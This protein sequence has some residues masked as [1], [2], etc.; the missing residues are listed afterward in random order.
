MRRSRRPSPCPSRPHAQALRE[1]VPDPGREPAAA[2]A[3]Q[4]GGVPG[5]RGG[6]GRGGEGRPGLIPAQPR[7]RPRRLPQRGVGQDRAG[8]SRRAAR[9]SPLLFGPFEDELGG[10]DAGIL[11]HVGIL[12]A[13]GPSSAPG[14]AEGSPEAAAFPPPGCGRPAAA[15]WCSRRTWR[16]RDLSGKI[17]REESKITFKLYVPRH[18]SLLCLVWL[19][20]CSACSWPACRQSVLRNERAHSFYSPW[21][22]VY[23]K[24]R[25]GHQQSPRT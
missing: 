25:H 22:P 15:L 4:P 8:V 16:V 6:Q 24:T 12:R 19:P 14:R 23:C 7:C 1:R 3:G 11:R 5:P 2:T 21:A 18:L 17:K 20:G 9:S 13:G 10:F